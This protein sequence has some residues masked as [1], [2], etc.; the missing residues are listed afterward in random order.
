MLAPWRLRQCV[1]VGSLNVGSVYFNDSNL[2]EAWKRFGGGLAEVW[3]MDLPKP[4]QS[5]SCLKSL[6]RNLWKGFGKALERLWK[7]LEIFGNLW[8]S[9]E[10]LWKGFGKAKNKNLKNKFFQSESGPY[11]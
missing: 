1:N 4:S 2:E 6:E 5:I 10:R 9:L 7:S 8:K 3:R 11:V